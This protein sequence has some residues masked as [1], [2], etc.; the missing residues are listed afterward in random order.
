MARL[1]GTAQRTLFRSCPFSSLRTVTDSRDSIS[2][3]LL[4]SRRLHA[5]PTSKSPFESN[6]LRILGNEIEY[7]CDYAPPQQV[8]TIPF[9]HCVFPLSVVC[10]S[11]FERNIFTGINS[12]IHFVCCFSF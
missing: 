7:R 1:V 8:P 6:I 11:R 4:Q 2:S 3:S 5:K 12:A 9:Y 10:N